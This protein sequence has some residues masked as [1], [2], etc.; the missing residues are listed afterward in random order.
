MRAALA[1]LAAALALVAPAPAA[2]ALGPDELDLVEERRLSE[3]LRELAFRTAAIDGVTR[4]RVLLPAGYERRPR[5][6]WPV[7][8]LLHGGFGSYRDW[9]ESGAAEAITAEAPL[10]V[11][12]PDTGITGGYTDWHNHGRG[13]PPMW[14]TYH[15]RQLVPW[16]DRRY[17]T[18][19]GRAGRAIAGASMGGGGAMTYAARHPDLFAAAASFSGAVDTNNPLVWPLTEFDGWNVGRPGARYGSRLTQE[20]RWRGHNPADLATNLAGLHLTVRTGTGLPAATGGLSVVELAVWLQNRSFHRRLRELGIPH[21][22]HEGPGRHD[23]PDWQRALRAL[24]AELPAV[25]ADPPAPPR[26]LRFRAIEPAYEVFGWRVRIARPAL[27]FSELRAAGGRF[28][29]RGSGRAT[30]T[31]P[32]RWRPGAAATVEVV[33]GEGRRRLRLRVGADCRLRIDV[34]LGA[35]NPVQQYT[36]AARLRGRREHTT[37]VTVRARRGCPGEAR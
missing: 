23:W 30:V 17:R 31:T 12:M 25:F 21:A 35:G 13:G 11:V 14:E 33:S 10:I 8:Y 32:P 28:S 22:W 20:V 18:V 1:A 19:A 6:R 37:H 29:L 3:R 36:L 34:P 4:V 15:L 26:E 24:V 2:A 9:T 7:L 16:I 27:E 5:R